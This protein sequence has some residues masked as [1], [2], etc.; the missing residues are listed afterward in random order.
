MDLM[1]LHELYLSPLS[2]YLETLVQTLTSTLHSQN[3]RR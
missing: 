3:T 1:I 2:L